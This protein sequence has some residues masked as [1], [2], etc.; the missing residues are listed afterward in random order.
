VYERDVL[1]QYS[2]A[3]M[4]EVAVTLELPS[5]TIELVKERVEIR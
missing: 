4:Y 5:Q 1:H 3:G 2:K